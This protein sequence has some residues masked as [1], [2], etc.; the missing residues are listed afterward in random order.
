MA[1]STRVKHYLEKNRVSY[2]FLRHTRKNSLVVIPSKLALPVEQC[3]QVEV[4]TSGTFH[5]MVVLPLNKAIDL[6]KINSKLGYVFRIMPTAAKN[7]LFAD[8]DPGACPPFGEAYGLQVLLDSDIKIEN[9]VYVESG[10]HNTMLAISGKDFSYLMADAMVFSLSKPK[11]TSYN[12]NQ[13]SGLTKSSLCYF[14]CLDQLAERIFC[15][16]SAKD[17]DNLRALIAKDDILSE[18]V[19]TMSSFISNLQCNSPHEFFAQREIALGFTLGRCFVVTGRDDFL[20][21]FWLHAL[22]SAVLM[23]EL[24][25]ASGLQLEIKQDR[26]FAASVM[27]NFGILLYGH[28]FPPEFGILSSLF[29]Q[30]NSDTMEFYERQLLGLGGAHDLLKEG[31]AEIGGKLLR[32]WHMSDLAV[33]LAR[34]H[35]KRDYI[36][37]NSGYVTLLQVINQLLCHYGIGDGKKDTFSNSE[38]IAFGI[39]ANSVNTRIEELIPK[40]SLLAKTML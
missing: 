10:S 16:N 22:I 35:H 7:K 36:G 9:K 8:S 20:T 3:L 31:H 32:Y 29:K 37:R 21:K 27:H 17:N 39:S 11:D 6:V 30:S 14:P 25:T 28:L 26:V 18:Q 15:M 40:L 1:V 2:Q 4:I 5:L 23:H 33:D 34:F 38:L 19:A 13:S 12:E 24:S